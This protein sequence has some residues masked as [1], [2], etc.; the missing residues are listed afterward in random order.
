M[1]SRL[2]RPCRTCRSAPAREAT[3]GGALVCAGCRLVERY[4]VCVRAVPT[5][6]DF[7]RI[8]RERTVRYI[9]DEQSREALR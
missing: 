8:I 2:E 5:L 4:C 6:D 1:Q 7:G 9:L 3:E